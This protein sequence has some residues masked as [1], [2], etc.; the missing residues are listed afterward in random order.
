LLTSHKNALIFVSPLFNA[1]ER[2]ERWQK[3]AQNKIDIGIPNR[4]TRRPY[5]NSEKTLSFVDEI[6]N[7]VSH[8]SMNS[9]KTALEYKGC[10][11]LINTYTDK[12]D[13]KPRIKYM[14]YK[15]QGI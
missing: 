12:V 3:M 14:V 7:E 8:L 2:A 6:T 11:F 9:F 15:V 13:K 5:T 1:Q 4:C 10:I